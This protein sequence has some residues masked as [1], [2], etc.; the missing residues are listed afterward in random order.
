MASSMDI[1]SSL[2]AVTNNS[3]LGR[4]KSILGIISSPGN[5]GSK[6]NAA[7]ATRSRPISALLWDEILDKRS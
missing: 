4:G 6:G 2:I 1:P 3:P 7:K 5:V